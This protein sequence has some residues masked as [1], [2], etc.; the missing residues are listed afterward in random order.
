MAADTILNFDK[1]AL[2]IVKVA[3]YVTLST[4]SSDLKMIVPIVEKW[5]PNFE[6]QDGGRRHLEK[7][8][9]G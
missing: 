3:F 4:F 6:I 8:T 9:S 7:Y 2:F 5:Q 1:N